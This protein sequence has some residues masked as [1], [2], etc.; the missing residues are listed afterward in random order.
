MSTQNQQY[1]YT[2][3][4]LDNYHLGD[5]QQEYE[6]GPFASCEMALAYAHGRI[7]AFAEEHA[8]ETSAEKLYSG[9]VQYGETPILVTDDP[10][11]NFN[12]SDYARQR[13][14]DV[15]PDKSPG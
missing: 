5:T 7:D 3:T 4:V 15:R 2:V 9:W 8:A 1:T 6:A 11:C 14:N 12:G 10:N 13:F